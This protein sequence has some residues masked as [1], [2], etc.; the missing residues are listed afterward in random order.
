MMFRQRRL[1]WL[2]HIRRMNYGRIPRDL[3][4]GELSAGKRN[5]GRPQLRYRDVC[6]REMNVL[7]I[8]KNE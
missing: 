6:K 2:G 5:I 4:Y 1:R 3:L 8:D 7:I